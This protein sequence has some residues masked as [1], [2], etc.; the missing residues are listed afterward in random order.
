MKHTGLTTLPINNPH[1]E[2]QPILNL[3]P[4]ISDQLSSQIIQDVLKAIGVD[5]LKFGCYKHHRV[6][7]DTSSQATKLH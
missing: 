3:L 7:H 5:F 1:T 4:D 2:L 6:Q